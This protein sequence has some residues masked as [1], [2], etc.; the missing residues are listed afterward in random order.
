MTERLR[1]LVLIVL[2]AGLSASCHAEVP[3]TA[4]AWNERLAVMAAP[5]ADVGGQDGYLRVETD[6]DLRTTWSIPYNLRRPYDIYTTDGKLLRG[7]VDNQGGG[8]GEN[9]RTISIE[10]GRYVIASVFGTTY[11]K[12]QVQVRRGERTDVP[13]DMFREAPAVFAN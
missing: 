5:N 1:P 9:P 4:V 12:V 6:T 10:P 8:G 11:R 3:Q 7:S 2:A 13:E